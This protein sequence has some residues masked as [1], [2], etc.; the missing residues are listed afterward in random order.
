MIL[1]ILLFL[2]FQSAKPP[3]FENQYARVLDVTDLPH[4]KGKAHSHAVDRVM[5]YLTAG[6]QQIVNTGGPVRNDHWKVGQVAWSAAGGEHTSE[7]VG[8]HPLRLIEV[9]LIAQPAAAKPFKISKL[10]PVAVDSR[11]YK[12]EFENAKVRVFRGKYG[13]HEEGKMHEHLHNRVV[14]YL[15]DSEMRVTS[16]DGKTEMR[17]IKAGQAQWGTPAKHKDDNA[18]AGPVEMIVV[19]LKQP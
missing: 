9:E 5:V 12:A 13:P 10:D 7:N 19:E 1:P 15:T 3:A 16:P 8:D 4:A 2:A 14:V 6:D 11:H 18:G 17:S